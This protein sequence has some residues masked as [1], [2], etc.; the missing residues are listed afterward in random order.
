[1]DRRQFLERSAMLAGAMCL[2]WNG[3]AESVKEM[4]KPKLRIGIL[5][6][7]HLT[8]ADSADVLQHAFEYYRSQNVDGIIIAGDMADWGEDFQLQYIAEAWRKVF[9]NDRGLKGQ[10]VEKLFIYGNHDKLFWNRKRTKDNVPDEEYRRAQ[11][12]G[13]HPAESWQRYFGEEYKPIWMKQVK[14]YVFIG[15]HYQD[16]STIKGLDSFLSSV[17]KKLKKQKPFFYIQHMHP[18]GTCSAPWTWGQDNGQVPKILSQYPNCISFSG[19]SHTSLTDERTLWQG[20]F[21]SIGTGSLKY[22]IPFGGRENTVV[23]AS[24][25]KLPSQMPIMQCKD[26]KQGQLMTVYRNYITLERREFVYDQSLGD[27]WVIPLPLH[28][29]GDSL[30]FASRAQVAKLPNFVK[31]DKVSITRAKGKDRYGVEQEQLTVHFPS[32]L[33][34]RGGVRAFDYEVQAL[35]AVRDIEQVVCTK[36]VFSRGY[37]LGEAQDQQEVLCV[38]GVSELPAKQKVRFVV[39]PVECFGGKGEP[40]SSNWIKI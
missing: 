13:L 2:D 36:R 38:F 14:G 16:N 9:P 25:E 8:D 35:V 18:K 20:T 40:I 11:A 30:S 3:F 27:N 33:R 29:N 4:G 7:I 26:G 37:Y 12:I 5:S 1:M 17:D 39:R 32:V 23:F 31:D 10:H 34:R 24:K 28:S 19:H 15:A 21:T 6:D 22:I